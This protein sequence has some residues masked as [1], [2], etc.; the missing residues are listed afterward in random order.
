MYSNTYRNFQVG[1]I[2]VLEYVYWCREI[3][4]T[5]LFTVLHTYYIPF[6]G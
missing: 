4:L 5:A 2:Q 1:I 3:V 6:N